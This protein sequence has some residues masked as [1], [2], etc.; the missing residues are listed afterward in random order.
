M[1]ESTEPI[2]RPTV[3]LPRDQWSSHPRFPSQ[4]LLLGS[5]ASFRHVSESLVEEAAA[6]GFVGPI[7]RLYRRWIS[8]M[9]SH[10]AYEE[11]KLYPFL[12]RRWR[13]SLASAER[14]HRALHRAHDVVIAALDEAS[15]AG[16]WRAGETLCEAL[17][18]HDDVL[19]AHLDVEEELVIPWLLE[20]TPAEF[21]EYCDEPIHLLLHRL[22]ERSLQ[23][24]E[25]G[26]EPAERPAPAEEV[27]DGQAG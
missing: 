9:R 11:G 19:R 3:R 27:H 24:R 5:H 23:R 10:E 14:G 21:A 4:A 26:A 8:A 2:Q 1:A 16:A 25:P 15:Q 7:D 13:V 6:G 20:L 22:D 18:H 12:E 17:R